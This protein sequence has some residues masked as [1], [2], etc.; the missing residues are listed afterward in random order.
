MHSC[1]DRDD[2][3]SPYRTRANLPS[4]DL[5]IEDMNMHLMAHMLSMTMTATSNKIPKLKA[6]TLTEECS[7][8]NWNQFQIQWDQFKCNTGLA[9]QDLIDQVLGC[10]SDP[11]GK[12]AINDGVNLCIEEVELIKR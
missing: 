12:A 8:T 1:M 5:I 11:L 10:L 7:E 2:G 6:P 3:L 9:G 4:E